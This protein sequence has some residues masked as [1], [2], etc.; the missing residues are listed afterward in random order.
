LLWQTPFGAAV[1]GSAAHGF[2]AFH[3]AGFGS[4]LLEVGGTQTAM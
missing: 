4:N 1:A 2:Y 3:H